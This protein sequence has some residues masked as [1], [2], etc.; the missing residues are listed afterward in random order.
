[1]GTIAGGIILAL[2]IILCIPLIF[3]LGLVFLYLGFYDHSLIAQWVDQT[4]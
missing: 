2:I 3:S 1:M 4:F